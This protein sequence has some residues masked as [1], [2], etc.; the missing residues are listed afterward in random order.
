MPGAIEKME[1]TA[2]DA[3][4]ADGDDDPPKQDYLDHPRGRA[5]CR[6]S[7]K[8]DTGAEQGHQRVDEI[9][10]RCGRLSCWD[11]GRL[12]SR[13]PVTRPKGGQAGSYAWPAAGPAANRP[14]PADCT[15]I[16]PRDGRRESRGADAGAERLTWTVR[17]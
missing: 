9:D 17:C 8:M 7:P 15:I 14:L 3:G 12:G 5:L 6:V 2:G 1:E 11:D 16:W 10:H 13:D 4:H